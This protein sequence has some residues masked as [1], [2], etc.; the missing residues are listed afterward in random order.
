M[1]VITLTQPWAT[2]VAIGQKSIETRSWW[3]GYRGPLAIHAAKGF[4][5]WAKELCF[6]KPFA[7]VLG[8][9]LRQN[10]G[11]DYYLE[12]VIKK[13]L[14]LGAIVAVCELVDV[15]SAESV[16]NELS[17]QEQAFG[18]YAP[19]RHAWLL[20]NVRQLPEPIPVKGK[21]GLWEFDLSEAEHGT[22]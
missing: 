1:K 9:Y 3:T 5:G 7:S 21:L 20:A 6:T 8:L 17:E 10:T 18:D 22:R 15:L 12:D 14:P 11:G 19:G 4:P 16:I 2:L 13:R